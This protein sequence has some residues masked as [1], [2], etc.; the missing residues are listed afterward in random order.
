LSGD[1]HVT[2]TVVDTANTT[3]SCTWVQH[4]QGPGIRFELCWDHT[5]TA[6]QGGADLDLHVHKPG[7]TTSWFTNANNGAANPDDCNFY[8]CT[9]SEYS[10]VNLANI[11]PPAWGYADSALAQCVGTDK[12][13]DWTANLNACHN[14]RLDLDNVNTVGRPENTNVD[15]PG[16]GDT[17]RAL[18]HYYGQDNAVSTNPIQEHPIVNVYCAGRLVASYGQAPS[19]LG[20]CPGAACFDR[21]SAWNAGLMWRVA[22]VT[23]Q[24]D[25]SGNTTGC[26]VTPIHPPGTNAGYYVTNNVT[27]Y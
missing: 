24:V 14:P 19:T 25:A 12:G 20:P 21:G 7:S 15:N 6:T 22:D 3:F 16:S 13:A 1:Y 8:N 5:G 18:V 10:A 4:V 9:A 27:T 2:M 23:A 11:A 26:S 17:F